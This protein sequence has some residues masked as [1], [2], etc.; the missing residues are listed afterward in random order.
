MTVETLR[1]L[2]KCDIVF[3]DFLDERA[4]IH[5]RAFCP[6]LRDLRKLRAR[7]DSEAMADVVMAALAP[8][9]T[10]AFL[11]YGHPMVLQGTADVLIRRC[12]TGGLPHTVT[13]SLSALDEIFVAIGVPVSPEGLQIYPSHIVTRRKIRLSDRVPAI[14]MVLSHLWDDEDCSV[15]GF[16]KHL[17]KIYAP[18]HPV[19]L[20]RCRRIIN[21]PLLRVATDLRGLA[22]ALE[23]LPL[24]ERFN[25]SLCIPARGQRV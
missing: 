20:I 8:G 6:D 23:N 9:R 12:R 5:M 19:L 14:I 11:C 2:K 22:A 3:H 24:K 17:K 15:A 18:E 10:T 1:T 7:D 16:V 13:A 4:E 25:T 21:D